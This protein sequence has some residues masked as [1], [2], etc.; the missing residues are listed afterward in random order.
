MSAIF[1]MSALSNS[2]TW[3]THIVMILLILAK[4]LFLE[5]F[6][7]MFGF[8]RAKGFPHGWGCLEPVIIS[9]RVK[10]TI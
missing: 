5:L 7:F 2:G 8:S 1:A 10:H 4:Y 6:E 3:I 9:H